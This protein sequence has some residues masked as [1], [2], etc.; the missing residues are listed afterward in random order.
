MIKSDGGLER[1]RAILQ[2]VATGITAASAAPAVD[3][4]MRGQMQRGETPEGAAWPL[5]Q[6]GRVALRGAAAAYEQTVSGNA[7]IMR[8]GGLGKKRYVIHNFAAGDQPERRQLPAGKIPMKLGQ[9]IRA[10]LIT[11]FQAITKAGK[12]GYASTRARGQKPRART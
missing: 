9:A 10:G 12:R 3:G 5:T 4:F 1:M 11:D 8:I 6:D 7:L 2:G